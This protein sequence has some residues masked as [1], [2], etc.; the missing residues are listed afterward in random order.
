MVAR[1]AHYTH[2]KLGKNDGVEEMERVER[3]RRL[4]A[5]QTHILETPPT[6]EQTEAIVA[7]LER[8]LGVPGNETIN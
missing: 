7:A 1:D 2:R 3:R 4:T 8:E 5:V 6:D